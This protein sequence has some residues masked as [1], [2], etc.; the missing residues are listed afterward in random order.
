MGAGAGH[1]L[2]AGELGHMELL[3]RNL[4]DY[5]YLDTTI[6]HRT[7]TPLLAV[8]FESTSSTNSDIVAYDEPT[9]FVSPSPTQIKAP[10]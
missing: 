8:D 7:G 2:G 3:S 5:N 1:D 10:V 4:N 9:A 6:R